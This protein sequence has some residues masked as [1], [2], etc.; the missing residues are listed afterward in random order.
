LDSNPRLHRE[1]ADLNPSGFELSAG[2]VVDDVQEPLGNPREF[3]GIVLAGG[4]LN[5]PHI[6]L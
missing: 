3:S 4:V 6:L 2:L 1:I 5:D